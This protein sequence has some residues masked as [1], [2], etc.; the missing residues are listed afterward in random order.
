MQLLKVLTGV[1]LCK[2]SVGD[3]FHYLLIC[4]REL[5]YTSTLY[6]VIFISMQT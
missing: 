6:Q 1:T 3:A 2:V 4:E 5:G